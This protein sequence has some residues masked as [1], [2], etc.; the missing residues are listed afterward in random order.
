MKI[1]VYA[2]AKDEE[3]NVDGFLIS[4]KDANLIVVADTGSTDNTVAELTTPWHWKRLPFD[5]G[6]KA[7]IKVHNIS[8]N[9]WRFD[10]ARNVALALVPAD[11]DVCVRLDLDERLQPGW[12]EAIEAVWKPGIT[13]LWYDFTHSPG[14][15]VRANNIHARHGYIWRCWDH[16]GLYPVAGC[17]TVMANT[18]ASIVHHQD[19]TKPRTAILGRLQR[20]VQEDPSSRTR[21]YLGREYFYYRHWQ[22]CLE[23]L[24]AYL[25]L[26]DATRDDERM[27]AMSMIAE[28]CFNLGKAE[29]GIRWYYKAIAECTTREPYLGLARR[30]YGLNDKEQ[31]LGLVQSALKLTNKLTTIYYKPG[32]WDNSPYLFAA[33]CARDLGWDVKAREYFTLA[34]TA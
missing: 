19:H 23:T 1:A 7:D 14:Y 21:Y 32:A 33:N 13:Q 24:V 27:D 15:T 26:P 10:T 3:K 29:D 12:R 5:S 2:I 6:W 34:E 28:S 9:P 16:E 17:R 11:I 18:T 20:A 4:A 31:A 22:K 30:L 25:A 8:I